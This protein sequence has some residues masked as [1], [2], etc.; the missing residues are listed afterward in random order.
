VTGTDGADS[1]TGSPAD[2]DLTGG[3]GND[4]LVGNGGND[5]LFGV[6]GADVLN[7]AGAGSTHLDGGDGN[8]TLVSQ[9]ATRDEDQCGA[10]TDSVQA[11][12]RDEV[13][14]DCENVKVAPPGKVVIGKVSVTKT[15]YVLVRI[16]CPATEPSCAGILTIKTKKKFGKIK[17]KLGNPSYRANGGKVAVV[18]ALIP[19]KF[20][21]TLG[22]AKKVAL[23]ITVTN[24]NAVTGLSSSK[25]ATKTVKTTVLRKKK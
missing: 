21:A 4:T 18:K 24:V 10:G 2:N 16:T 19:P 23:T 13:H 22:K 15:G 6:R 3:D 14:G 11:D 12:G 7:A 5:G 25:S 20:R 1:L 8:D 17:L 9:D